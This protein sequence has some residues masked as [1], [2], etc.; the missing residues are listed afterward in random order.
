M[1]RRVELGLKLDLQYLSFADIFGG[2]MDGTIDVGLVL[3]W[4]N[5][6]A[7]KASIVPGILNMEAA[8]RSFHFF[9]WGEVLLRRTND[10]R[11]VPYHILTVPAGTVPKAAGRPGA[12]R[13]S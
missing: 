6:A 12:L 4:C 11:G 13:Q 10:E 8:D 7:N 3:N 5:A 1:Q 9:P 2:L